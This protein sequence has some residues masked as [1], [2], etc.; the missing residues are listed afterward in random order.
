MTR[1][2]LLLL[3]ATLSAALMGCTADNSAPF[4][5]DGVTP[6]AVYDRPVIMRP[7]TA[8][9]VDLEGA[10]FGC[11]FD[12]D[13]GVVVDPHSDVASVKLDDTSNPKRL[14]ILAKNKGRE[15]IELTLGGAVVS[16]VRLVVSQ[17]LA[18]K[19][20]PAQNGLEPL[21]PPVPTPWGV[22]VNHG[23]LL[24]AQV[25]TDDD[26]I[27]LVSEVRFMDQENVVAGD[28]NWVKT[29]KFLAPGSYLADTRLNASTTAGGY[30][31][32]VAPDDIVN[33]SIDVLAANQS[34]A[35]SVLGVTAD[36][37]SI[38]GLDP[39]VTLAGRPLESVF[40]AWLFGQDYK[41]GD[42]VRASWNGIE[43]TMVL[44]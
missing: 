35:I 36:G 40:G 37:R 19:F 13:V 26:A 28:E 29:F 11:Y 42:E 20:V 24:S 27:P 8:L 4:A 39:V 15:A 5:C 21:L 1:T 7:N 32:A 23:V 43:K 14:T 10:P 34:V 38:I 9:E 30:V 12:A 44:N 33:L 17:S 31:T 16:T 2:T 25:T 41:P 22:I 3:A 6:V 18:L